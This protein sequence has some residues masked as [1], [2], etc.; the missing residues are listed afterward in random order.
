MYRGF[1]V[2]YKEVHPY[3]KDDTAWKEANRQWNQLRKEDEHSV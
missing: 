3:P 2:I 1:V